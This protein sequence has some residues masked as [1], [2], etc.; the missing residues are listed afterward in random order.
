[1][2]F[3]QT[4]KLLYPSFLCPFYFNNIFLVMGIYIKYENSTP[5][6]PTKK[7]LWGAG[8]DLAACPT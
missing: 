3:L 6:R 7:I 8:R 4:L 5:I 2:S 1:M